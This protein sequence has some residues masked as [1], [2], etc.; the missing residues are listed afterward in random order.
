MNESETRAE[1]IDPALAAAG[2]GVV[3]ESAIR[4]E[5]QITDGRIQVGG[6]RGQQLKADYV[7]VY[8]G[9]QLAVI[10]AK[11]DEKSATDGVGQA[12]E[13][14][15][16]LDC[17]TTFATN[18]RDIYQICMKTGSEGP[19]DQYPT[20]NELWDRTFAEANEWR[21]K[22]NRE[23]LNRGGGLWQPRYYQE[24]AIN[25]VTGAIADGQQRILLTMAT[26]T[27]K[28]AVAFEIVWKLFYTRWNLQRDGSRRPRVLFLADRN[29]LANQAF[30]AF[31]AFPEDA[32]RRI[33]PDEIAKSGRVPTNG[34]IF[35]TIFQTFMSGPE[36]SAYFGEYPADYFDLVIVDECH[37]GG[38]SDESTWRDI[39][40]YFSPAVQLGL[41]ATPK[42]R[43]NVDTYSYFGDPVYTYSLKEGINDGFLTPFRVKRIRTTLDEYIYSPDDKV[44]QGEVQHN[45]QYNEADFNR[46]IEIAQREHYRVKIFLDEANQ[47]EKSLVFCRTQL[48]AGVVRDL[49]NQESKSSD[50]EYCCRVTAE[51]GKIGDQ[52]LKAFQDNDKTIPTVLTTSQ[53][54]STGVDARNVRNIVLMRPVNDMIEFKQIVGRGT[55]IYDGKEYFTIYDFVNIFDHFADPEWD[56]DPVEPDDCGTCGQYPCICVREPKTC[57]ECGESPCVCEKPD[58][59]ECHQRPCICVKKVI[60]ELGP[61]KMLQ[62][63][64][65]TET[66]FWG[67]D[68]RPLT[69]E[70]FIKHLFGKLPE[71]YSTEQELRDIWSDPMTRKSLLEKLDE[72]G[73]SFESLNTLRD[74]VADP[75]S[76][77]FDVLE[78]ISFQVSPIT[79]AA[80]VQAA[81]SAIF[82]GLSPDQREFVEFVLAKYIETGV[83]ALDREI[84]PEL[85]KLKYD[86]IEDALAVFGTPDAITSTFVD[87]QKHLYAALSG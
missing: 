46:V 75:D 19:I 14:A 38:A 25:R 31:S 27:G 34:S 6:R 40:K 73:Y 30:N 61:G 15:K 58:C 52:H 85:L 77:L 76:D 33:R 83:E 49:I 24:N 21:D 20:P 70:D 53:K 42:R 80:R 12:K 48:H 74:L 67:P 16:R 37:R 7:L 57:R 71:F 59:P 82:E 5:F 8:R 81:E 18:G 4:R 86:A 10:E 63:G 22:F 3:E 11:S 23:P 9:R 54:L 50:P 36:G 56:G 2:W 43:N 87:F 41:T 62:L 72:A 78:L 28:T 45:K 69:S 60:I 84:L 35:F 29:V 13:Y 47:K 1:L 39:L 44:I 66:S 17:Q 26:G 64:H 68:G 51:D 55:R 79:R 65:C 32:L